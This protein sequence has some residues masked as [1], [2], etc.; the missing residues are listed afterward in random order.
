MKTSCFC[1]ELFDGYIV[2]D[3]VVVFT[4][5]Q[6]CYTVLLLYTLYI[7]LICGFKLKTSF[8]LSLKSYNQIVF[9]ISI[10]DQYPSFFFIFSLWLGCDSCKYIFLKGNK[11]IVIFYRVIRSRCDQA[12]F[13]MLI[14][15]LKVLKNL[16]VPIHILTTKFIRMISVEITTFS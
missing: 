6:F 11:N 4:R 8:F 7:N 5:V 14:K 1:F 12:M 15:L 10:S 9:F 13:Y 3:I 2:V 16:R